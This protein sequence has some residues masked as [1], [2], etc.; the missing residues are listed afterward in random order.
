MLMGVD[1]LVGHWSVL[2]CRI[3]QGEGML[4]PMGVDC[5]SRRSSLSDLLASYIVLSAFLMVLT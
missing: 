5:R 4:D 3:S 1:G 2:L